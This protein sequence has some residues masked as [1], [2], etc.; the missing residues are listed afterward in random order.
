[1]IYI[2]KHNGTEPKGGV[3]AI[4]FIRLQ[5]NVVVYT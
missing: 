2:K 5:K 4:L 1:M 3:N